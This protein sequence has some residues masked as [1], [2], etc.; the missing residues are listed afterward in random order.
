VYFMKKCLLKIALL[1]SLLLS[2]SCLVEL[3]A[4]VVMKSV[5]ITAKALVHAPK[6]ILHAPEIITLPLA[7]PLIVSGSDIPKKIDESNFFGEPYLGL[8]NDVE[9][10]GK[11]EVWRL[12]SVPGNLVIGTVFLPIDLCAKA[13]IDDDYDK[14]KASDDDKKGEKIKAPKQCQKMPPTITKLTPENQVYCRYARVEST[15]AIQMA[16]F[17]L[18]SQ[19]VNL[20]LKGQAIQSATT[21]SGEVASRSIDNKLSGRAR[22]KSLSNTG[23]GPAWW[24]LDLGKEFA[25]DQVAVWKRT[26]FFKRKGHRPF[27]LNDFQISLFDNEHKLVWSIT[28][29]SNSGVL[30]RSIR[31]IPAR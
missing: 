7:I 21:K 10:I 8:R 1:F 31:K 3:P 23:P 9:G 18:F 29:K 26:F 25:V 6:I 22:H 17:Q 28:V 16:E 4:V 13:I 5:E 19:G 15:K 11:S 14:G 20:A 24:E 30:R 2:Q 27:G 12:I